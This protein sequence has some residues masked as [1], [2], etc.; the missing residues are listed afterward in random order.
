MLGAFLYLFPRARVTSLFPFLFFLPLRF[1]AWIVLLFWF[2]LQWLAAQAAAP[3]PGRGLSGPRGR[4]R[5]RASSTRGR[6]TGVR[7]R[8]RAAQLTA[9][10][11]ES[12][13]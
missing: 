11:G 2:A 8:V 3:R 5:A 7:T 6:A 9:T 1:P 12:Q 13:P 10:E 4:L